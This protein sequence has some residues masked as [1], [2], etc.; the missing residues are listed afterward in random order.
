MITQPKKD[1][2]RTEWGNWGLAFLRHDGQ[3]WQVVDGT[4]FP[5]GPRGPVDGT[6][7]SPEQMRWR[8]VADAWTQHGVLPT[9]G[10]H[11]QVLREAP[12]FCIQSQGHKPGGGP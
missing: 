7:G 5:C 10:L 8:R 3:T 12:N 11:S 9:E 2:R 4:H 1:D 6:V